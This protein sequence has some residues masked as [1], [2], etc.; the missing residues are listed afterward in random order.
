MLQKKKI[1]KRKLLDELNAT[2]NS[3]HSTSD[4][5]TDILQICDDNSDDDVD[6]GTEIC[7][8]CEE[9]GKDEVWYRCT[10]CGFWVHAECSDVDS[11]TNYIC[12]ICTR[13][14][15]MSS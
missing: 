14:L 1:T 2:N 7:L 15:R 9:R 11:P 10:N 4:T 13:R 3:D 8:I 12:D 5:D 6:D